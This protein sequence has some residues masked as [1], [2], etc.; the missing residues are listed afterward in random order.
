MCLWPLPIRRDR[1]PLLLCFCAA[2]PGDTG[3]G[4]AREG[5]TLAWRNDSGTQPTS[6][7]FTKRFTSHHPEGSRLVTVTISPCASDNSEAACPTKSNR[8]LNIGSDAGMDGAG[9]VLR[10]DW[11]PGHSFVD[12]VC[13]HVRS[14]DTVVVDAAR[15]G[16]SRCVAR[17]SKMLSKSNGLYGGGGS[18]LWSWWPFIAVNSATY[19]TIVTKHEVEA[20][21]FCLA[22][23]MES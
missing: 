22:L 10:I 8:A 19:R 20:L 4:G 16:S 12:G 18:S 11:H 14:E 1:R 23:V 9:T 3:V 15:R 2:L 21:P 6:V 13:D 5:A 7:G 17:C